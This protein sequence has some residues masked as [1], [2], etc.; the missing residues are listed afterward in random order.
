MIII[1]N[2]LVS[3]ELFENYFCCNLEACQGYCCVEGDMGAPVDP[4]EVGDL[5]DNYPLFKKYM[6][7]EAIAKVDAE[8]TF[9]YDLEGA[10]V[11][12]L[13][14]DERCAYAYY[15]EKGV[16]KC[17]IEKAYLNGE[18]SF[19]KPISCHLYPI[20][21]KKLP[22]YEALNYHR[23]F[24][25]NEACELGLKLRLPVFRFLK[26]PIIR[27]YG[28]DFYQK[29]E[30][31]YIDMKAAGGVVRNSKGEVLMIFRRS[32]WDFPKG[33]MEEGESIEETAVREVSEETGLQTLTIIRALPST[34]HSYMMGGKW[35]GK[36]TFWYEM[37]AKDEEELI[38]Q[39]EEDIVEA[40]WV[41]EK[42]VT[43]LLKDSYPTLRELWKSVIKK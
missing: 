14:S 6:S 38:P 29:L 7:A 43:K 32:K 1:N 20:R 8:G 21:I 36:E 37:Q 16:A 18:I 33:K 25:C 12:P 10:F 9:D 4:E 17:A 30:D 19:R 13:L 42:E 35:V 22:D 3:D 28:E 24:V 2:I 15:D 23:W 41:K 5:E 27:K 39:T 34:M 31:N 11:T 26:E 40:R